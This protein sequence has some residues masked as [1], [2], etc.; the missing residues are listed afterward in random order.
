MNQFRTKTA[1]A[2]MTGTVCVID[3]NTPLAWAV[4]ESDNRRNMIT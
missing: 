4:F 1:Y 3:S 2:L